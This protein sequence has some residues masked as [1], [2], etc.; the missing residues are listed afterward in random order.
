MWFLVDFRFVKKFKRMIALAE[1]KA[2]PSFAD[3]LVTQRGSRLSIQP[4]AQKHFE[5]IVTLTS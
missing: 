3:M 5:K 2:S 4:V 1:L